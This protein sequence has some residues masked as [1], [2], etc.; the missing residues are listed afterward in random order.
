MLVSVVTAVYNGEKYLQECIESILN[1]TYT[2]IEYIIVNDGSTDGTKEILDAIQ[3]TRVRVMHLDRNHGA[4]FCLNQGINQAEGKW[5]AIQ[6]ADDVSVPIRLEEQIE[7]FK[8]HPQAIGVSSFVKGIAGKE[9]VS[10]KS[11]YAHEFYFNKVMSKE[12]VYTTR[13]LTC[14]VCHGSVMFLKE[15]FHR[16]GGYNPL[17]KIVYDRD[18]WFRLFEVAPFEKIPKVLYH[19]RVLPNSLSHGDSS[20]VGKELLLA[21]T[22]GIRDFIH[23]KKGY[24][25]NESPNVIVLAPRNKCEFFKRYIA[26]HVNMNVKR[27][28]S[29]SG[30]LREWEIKDLISNDVID[31]IFVMN[32]QQSHRL[33]KK[34]IRKGLKMNE[35][36]FKIE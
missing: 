12:E 20:A 9:P 6:D 21:A 7:Y 13:F 35:H 14:Y 10:E 2:E 4:A 11:L 33:M 24:L 15:V 28:I 34:L 26:P 17:F 16:L 23:R 8:K 29:R 18:L 27:Y 31:A 1:Q 25:H 3:D 32:N 19:Y 5:I 22:M 36:I 30:E